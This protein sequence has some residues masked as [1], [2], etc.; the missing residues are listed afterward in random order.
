MKEEILEMKRPPSTLQDVYK[1]SILMFW[2]CLFMFVCTGLWTLLN[3]FISLANWR[4]SPIQQLTGIA[5]TLGFFLA[6]VWVGDMMED[7]REELGE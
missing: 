5:F 6:W 7:M 4:F 2:L 1:N 3:T